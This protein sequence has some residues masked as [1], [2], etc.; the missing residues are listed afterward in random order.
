ME[1]VHK[2]FLCESDV[3]RYFGK[4]IRIMFTIKQS[5]QQYES[6]R[7]IESI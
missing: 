7:I 2:S 6:Q 3:S 4:E 5:G 1:G